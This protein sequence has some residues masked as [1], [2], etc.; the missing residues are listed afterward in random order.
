MTITVLLALIDL[1]STT[2]LNAVLS[3]VVAGLYSSFLVAG[4]VLLL[5]R[6]TTPY[7]DIRWGPFA[8]GL[9]G[10]PLNIL[11]VAWTMIGIS[12]RPGHQMRR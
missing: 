1:G 9:F 6:L 4:S 5:K 7:K 3:L 12:S 8:L 2:A 11:A 10:L